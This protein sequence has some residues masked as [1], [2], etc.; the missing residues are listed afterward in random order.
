MLFLKKR[1]DS[2]SF[3]CVLDPESFSL[4]LFCVLKEKMV[5]KENRKEDW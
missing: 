3:H 2:I 5:S 4:F 1:M